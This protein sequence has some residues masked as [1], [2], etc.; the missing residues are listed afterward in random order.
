MMVGIGA[1]EFVAPWLGLYRDVDNLRILWGAGDITEG[2]P[3]L[4]RWH[5]NYKSLFED[6]MKEGLADL[7]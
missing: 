1:D 5:P 2:R 4:S 6:Y 3:A 7:D